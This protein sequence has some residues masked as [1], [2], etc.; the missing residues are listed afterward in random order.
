MNANY[1]IENLYSLL[2]G[3]VSG[4]TYDGVRIEAIDVM[5]SKIK[6]LR[7]MTTIL[8]PTTISEFEFMKKNIFLIN[9]FDYY[10]W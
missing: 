3:R 5:H 1:I 10:K 4:N 9:G 8:F 6:L 2:G 7:K